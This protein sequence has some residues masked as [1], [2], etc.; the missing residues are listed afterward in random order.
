MRHQSRMPALKDLFNNSLDPFRD[1][2]NIQ[3]ELDKMF[4]DIFV[5]ED[6]SK[7]LILHKG[8]YPKINIKECDK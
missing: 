2:T 1:F 5:R 6:C 3:E 4:N 8:N 7:D